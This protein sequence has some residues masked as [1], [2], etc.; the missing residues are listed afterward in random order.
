MQVTC[1]LD[2]DS[3]GNVE[4]NVAAQISYG[5]DIVRW[6]RM[7]TDPLLVYVLGH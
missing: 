7:L 4:W 2:G 3:S 5:E 1:D 6:M